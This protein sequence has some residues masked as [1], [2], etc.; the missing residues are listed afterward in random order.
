MTGQSM[1]SLTN[2]ENYSSRD[3]LRINFLIIQ[4]ISCDLSLELQ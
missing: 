1:F 3:N 4:N 2:K